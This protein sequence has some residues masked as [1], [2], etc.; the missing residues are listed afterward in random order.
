[1]AVHKAAIIIIII[2]LI[3]SF[4][5]IASSVPFI[6]LHG[7]FVRVFCRVSNS[8]ISGKLKWKVAFFFPAG[9]GDKCSNSGVKHFTELLSDW[10]GSQGYCL[11]VPLFIFSPCLKFCVCLIPYW[12]LF[13][14]IGNGSWDSWTMP[15][16][17]QVIIYMNMFQLPRMV[18]FV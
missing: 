18:N 6:V 5:T 1:M 12:C 4:I 8:K 13:R 11:Y 2:A 14:E 15:L 3:C 10:S 9:I 17:D 16:L 7:K